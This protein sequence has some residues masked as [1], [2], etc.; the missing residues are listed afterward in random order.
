MQQRQGSPRGAESPVSKLAVIWLRQGHLPLDHTD[1]SPIQ[2]ANLAFTIS[3]GEASTASPDNPYQ[4]QTWDRCRLSCRGSSLQREVPAKQR[5]QHLVYSSQDLYIFSG[6]LL[7]LLG[8]VR[9][10]WPCQSR[11]QHCTRGS[12]SL[13]AVK[14]CAAVL[15]FLYENW[16][17]CYTLGAS[18]CISQ[19]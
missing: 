16:L 13:W 1:Q 12:F 6:V 3:S 2:P 9:K 5:C 14:N 19:E 18:H 7:P 15:Q 8:K 10:L 4:C 11:H 17:S